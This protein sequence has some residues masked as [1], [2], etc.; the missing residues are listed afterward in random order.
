[1]RVL[2]A[3][4]EIEIRRVLRLVLENG[5]Y[6][7]VEVADG[8]AA[9]DEVKR[10]AEID[11]VI[12]DIMMP[13]MSG[14]SAVEKIRHFSTVPVLFLT[15]RSFVA[16]KENAYSVG[17]DDYIVKP[18]STK[19][20]LMKVDALTR[21]YNS[22]GAKGTAGAG[23]R[24]SGGVVVNS[25]GRSVTKNGTPVELREKEMDVL[26]YLVANKGRTVGPD[27]L[28]R[29]VWGEIPLAS[30]GNNIT[31]H[32]LNLRRRLEDAPSSPKI[33]RTVWGKGYQID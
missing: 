31:V 5:G 14:T 27:E 2:I 1:M 3:D 7:V 23:I 18:F 12:M 9:V 16:D 25:E 13:R 28:Y 30:S 32:I 15:A 24:L 26:F 8:A 19:E 6:E 22:Y 17:G 33:I 21:R 20:L 10:D 4:D 11:L 29:A